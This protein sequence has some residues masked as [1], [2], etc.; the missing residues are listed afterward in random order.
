VLS[1]RVRKIK[2]SP[3]L[4]ITAKAKAMKAE[5]IDVV[6]FGAGEPD[7]DTADHIKEAAIEA[8]RAGFTKYTPSGGIPELKKAIVDKLR[9]DSGLEYEP[10]EVLVSVGGKHSF[11]NLAQAFL[12]EGDE[13]IIPA[14][15]WVS[16]PPMVTLAGATPVILDTDEKTEFKISPEQLRRAITDKTKALVLCSPSNP[17]GSGYSREELAGLGEIIV[18]KKIA[19]LSDEI[20][21]KFTYDGFKWMSIASLSPELKERTYVLNAVSKTYSMTGWRIGYAAGN[22]ETIAAMNK[23]QDQS[24]SNPTSISQKAA[25]AALTGPQDCVARMLEEFK[26]RRRVIVEGLNAIEGITCIWPQGAFY[27]FPNVSALYARKFEG[28]ALGSSGGFTEYLLDTAR[29]AVVPGEGFGADNY[30]R[31]SYATSMEV[32]EKGLSRIAE[33]VKRLS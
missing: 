5:G 29:V 6:G 30:V 32:I 3:T 20:Y 18:E 7:F 33:A 27:V 28:K 25:V 2:P 22:R 4:A 21:E 26:K 13:V 16:Y 1:D 24:T 31:L 23:V 8:I 15:Y 19:V 12:Q 14:P 17:T 9:S 11:Y 10:A